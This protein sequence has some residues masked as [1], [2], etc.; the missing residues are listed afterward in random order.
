MMDEDDIRAIDL[1]G[2]VGARQF[3]LGKRYTIALWTPKQVEVL[4]AIKT[5][6][7]RRGIK[8]NVVSLTNKAVPEKYREE[9]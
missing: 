4:N 8:P 2:L 6:Y 9:T 7:G 3:M 1:L 5:L